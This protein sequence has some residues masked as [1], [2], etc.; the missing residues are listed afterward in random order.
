V[1][2]IYPDDEVPEGWEH[3]I[4]WNQYLA[5]KWQEDGYNIIERSDPLPD[6]EAWKEKAKSEEDI[7]DWS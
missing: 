6:A 1:E 2:A 3:Y 7:Q 4:E 5:E